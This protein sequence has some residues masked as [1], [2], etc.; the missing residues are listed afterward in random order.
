MSA[1]VDDG[2]QIGLRQRLDLVSPVV[3]VPQPA[4][5]EQHRLALAELRVEEPRPVDLGEAALSGFGSAGVGGS[6]SH[7]GLS[8]LSACPLWTRTGGRAR[9]LPA[10]AG[11]VGA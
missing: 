2:D 5:Q 1:R 3:G 7:G 8:R 9:W 4:V 11:R 10:S 6:V